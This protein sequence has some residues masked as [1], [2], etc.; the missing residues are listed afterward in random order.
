M[1]FLAFS[2]LMSVHGK[3]K[4]RLGQRCPPETHF[5]AQSSLFLVAETKLSAPLER[6]LAGV[7]RYLSFWKFTDYLASSYFFRPIKGQGRNRED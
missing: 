7:I 5:D 4:G 1:L 6:E 2:F 3:E